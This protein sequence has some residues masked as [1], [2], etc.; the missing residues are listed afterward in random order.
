MFSEILLIK[1]KL[2][3]KDFNALQKLLQSRFTKIAKGFGKGLLSAVKGGGVVG[4][5]L[6]LID[7]LLN[8]LQA[9]QEAI[10]KS[11]KTSA[12]IVTNAKQFGTTAGRLFKLQQLAESK[13]ID[14]SSLYMLIGKFQT[15]VAEANANPN[16]PSTV[17]N[18]ADNPDVAMGFFDFIQA[19][20]K[21]T[22]EQQVLAQQ[23]VFGEKQTLKMASFL[24]TDFADQFKRIGAQSA[25]TYTPGLL[26]QDRLDEMG[27]ALAVR[28]NMQD[29]LVK[30]RI[31]NEAMVI[32]KA[33]GDKA[34]MARENAQIQ[35]YEDLK[36]MSTTMTQIMGLVDTAV[37]GLGMLTRL[38]TP[39]INQAVAFMQN[40]A[41]SPVMRGI[42]KFGKGD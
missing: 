25:A 35:S 37:Q 3:A 6:G 23:S 5:A 31:I 33:E 40:F 11:L 22:K 20:Q 30:S 4:V 24:Q 10:D 9:V 12:D 17:R 19:L 7:K 32:A 21:M 34:A 15:A 1:A 29:K 39:F 13:G 16:E 18:F 26:K 41:K 28:A 27:N 2:D 8:P 42:F 38:L 36:A 14:E